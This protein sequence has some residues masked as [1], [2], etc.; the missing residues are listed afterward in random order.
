M[1]IPTVFAMQAFKMLK[2]GRQGCLCA[3]KATELKDLDL[4]ENSI[5]KK[6][7]PQVFQEVPGL[8]PRR[9]IEFTV[10]L[11]PGTAHHPRHLIEWYLLN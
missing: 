11:V 4:S 9:G 3:I 6:E 7:R 5:S 1:A 10:E 8:P 2:K